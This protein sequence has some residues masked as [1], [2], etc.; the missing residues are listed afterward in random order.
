MKCSNKK[1]A[2]LLGG[3]IVTR[4]GGY[5]GIG[6]I[7]SLLQVISETNSQQATDMTRIAQS[8]VTAQAAAQASSRAKTQFLA[9]M[10]HEI[11]TPLNGVLAVAELL[12]QQPLPSKARTY[13]Q[14]ILDSGEVLLRLLNDTLDMS[15][16]DAGE[17][18]LDLE[19]SSLQE[20]MDDVQ[21]LWSARAAQ[22]NST[23]IVSYQGEHDLYARF[24][25]MRLKQVFNNLIGNALKF[26]RSGVIEA[27]LT[28]VRDPGDPSRIRITGYIRD[29]GPG[30]P[31]DKLQTLFDPFVC[32][33]NH[34]QG[35]AGLGL[36]ICQQILTAMGGTIR[37]SNNA[38]GG[39]H[40]AFEFSLESAARPVLPEPIRAVTQEANRTRPPHI[41]IVDDNATNRLVAQALC[42]SFGCT[43]VCVEDGV[44]AVEAV[45]IAP[46]DL[47]LMDIKMP[48]M[49]GVEATRTIRSLPGGIGALPILA[50]TANASAE[51]AQHYREAG[52]D[53]VLAKPIK[54]ERLLEALNIALKRDV[55]RSLEMGSCAA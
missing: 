47:I 15:R 49:N 18:R 10:S 54:A 31:A 42:D 33:P 6:T 1:A 55:N 44:E 2:A 50:L 27:N 17:L 4:E 19:D 40:F 28:P 14:T 34:E 43:S 23:L 3:F 11:R 7:L 52:M 9:V 46:F 21:N 22:D 32:S 38:G 20:L 8:L 35:G 16:A 25:K 12:Q 48:R 29:N 13:V 41:L 26:A 51:D 37:A 36:A 30:I 5:E 45:K 53:E 24:D 39:A